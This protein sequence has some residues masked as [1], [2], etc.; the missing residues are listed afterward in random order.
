[1]HKRRLR[2]AKWIGV[3]PAVANCLACGREFKVPMTQMSRTADA[4]QNLQTQFDRH[5]CEAGD[6]SGAKKTA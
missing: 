6:S 1:M 4:Q 5:I 2:V 3:T